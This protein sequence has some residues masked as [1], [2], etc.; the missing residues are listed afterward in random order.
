MPA[1]RVYL[2][3]IGRPLDPA[4]AAVP[5]LDRGFLFG[6]AVF[7]TLRTA[8]GRPVAWG[9]HTARLRRSAAGIGLDLPWSDDE[10]RAFVDLTHGETG[11]ADS[12]VRI[13]VTRG[14][15]PLMLD[16]RKA[17]TPTLA[18]LAVPLDLPDE[19]GYARGLR[20]RIVDVTRA[21]ASALDPT[22]KTANYLPNIQ[23]LRQA[24]AA[25]DDEAVL[26]NPAGLVAEGATSNVFAVLNG[27]LFTPP[28]S[29]GILP[30]ITRAAVLDLAGALAI[31][32]H[33]SSLHPFD[34]RAADEVF[35]TSSVRG[36]IAV[37]TLDGFPVAAGNEGPLTNKLRN[38]YQAALPG[39]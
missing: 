13:V 7:E 37:T 34:L 25:G 4:E 3:T 35:L 23:A 16:P 24:L 18:V 10:L 17:L 31:P 38:A 33:E 22:F 30:G 5:V 32:A 15:A 12:V 27:V 29:D 8:G 1:S 26:I 20:A 19:A 39:L 36:P 6:D 2:S 28:V 14:V 21:P 9:A 11:N